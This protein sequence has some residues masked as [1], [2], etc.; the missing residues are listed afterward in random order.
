MTTTQLG[1][2]TQMAHP[3]ATF[4]ERATRALETHQGLDL[5]A[6]VA[7]LHDQEIA[8]VAEQAAA[9]R[10]SLV[11]VAEA[12][13]VDQQM[14]AGILDVVRPML[15]RSAEN[16]ARAEHFA[17]MAAAVRS[18]L[19]E[20]DTASEAVDREQLRRVLDIQGA[21][22]PFRPIVLGFVPSTQYRIGHFRQIQTNAEW[23]LPFAGYSVCEEMAERPM[24]TH[25]AFLHLGVVR[26][27]PQLYAEFGLVMD[28]ME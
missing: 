7:M 16:C 12:A 27:R 24:T 25:V 3:P 18:L 19:N 6:F 23:H 11:Q 9:A 21:P 17:G 22:A 4:R 1:T 2:V 26:P 10:N 14:M 28:H 5:V 8:E 13:A 20:S 15:R